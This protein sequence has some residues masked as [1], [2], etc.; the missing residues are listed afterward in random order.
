MHK[1]PDIKYPGSARLFSFCKS[2]LDTK[3]GDARV[4]DQDVGQILGFDPA[5]CSH[6]KKGRKNIKSVDAL[7]SIATH[8]GVDERLVIDVA[9]GAINDVEALLEFKGLGLMDIAPAVPEAVRKEWMRRNG[10]AWTT[11]ME[12]KLQ[13]FF[14]IKT[15]EVDRVI[16]QI[17]QKIQFFE[18]PL[19]L[20]ELL[21][22]YPEI[23]V[24]NKSHSF[25][26]TMN[27][28]DALPRGYQHDNGKFELLVAEGAML[29]PVMRFH[30]VKALAPFFVSNLM[31]RSS[32]LFSEHEIYVRDVYANCFAARFLVPTAL[33]KAELKRVDLSRDMIS[34]L[35]EIFWVSRS[36][37]NRRLKDSLME[38]VGV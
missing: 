38:P 37:M 5:D 28:V 9:S 30:I 14:T 24:V 21:R 33:V 29:R 25:D 11:E 7:K 22:A 23:R 19:F 27:I 1:V 26:Q 8:L 18:A 4:I 32:N 35:A 2:V 13:N 31:D 10:R 6:W 12:H 17:H 16:S 15:D 3:F 20:P 34:Q 36:L